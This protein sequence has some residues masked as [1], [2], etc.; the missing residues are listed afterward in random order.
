MDRDKATSELFVTNVDTY[1][2][3]VAAGDITTLDLDNMDFVNPGVD[4]NFD[5]NRYEYIHG[6]GKAG[7][8]LDGSEGWQLDILKAG[9]MTPSSVYTPHG[10]RFSC[11]DRN[12]DV[13]GY[14]A[15]IRD[16]DCGNAVKPDC[17]GQVHLEECELPSGPDWTLWTDY[18]EC[19]KSCF[20]EPKL[21]PGYGYK[22]RG[23]NCEAHT[24]L[25]NAAGT[26]VNIQ[27]PEK[28]YK[29]CVCAT[30][31]QNEDATACQT[32]ANIEATANQCTWQMA[33]CNTNKPCPKEG[34]SILVKSCPA[35]GSGHKE[36]K[37]KLCTGPGAAGA[38]WD[39][40]EPYTA[41]HCKFPDGEFKTED[42]TDVVCTAASVSGNC[43]NNIREIIVNGEIEQESCSIV[44]W[45]D[46]TSCPA[47][48]CAERPIGKSFRFSAQAETEHKDCPVSTLACPKWSDWSEWSE[49][50]DNSK[51]RSR[52]CINPN[53]LTPIGGECFGESTET[54]AC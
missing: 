51:S 22:I 37:Q 29:G 44:A 40:A 43:V 47:V 54:C 12:D 26:A 48:T 41:D 28:L 45:S 24:D 34:G 4:Y 33:K 13:K 30:D 9:W 11:R 25:F 39:S 14:R 49:C 38:D 2:A 20:E 32:S 52:D 19:S 15:R 53:N 23:R 27:L 6:M 16:P 5:E 17:C 7:T 10:W 50:A 3:D 18:S 35:C 8:V 1:L 46:W 36:I 21:N 31:S 42:C